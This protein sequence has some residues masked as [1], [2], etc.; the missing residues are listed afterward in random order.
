MT[1]FQRLISEAEQSS[2]LEADR[3]MDLRI[4]VRTYGKPAHL[5]RIA[6]QLHRHLKVTFGDAV[7]FMTLGND[8]LID[9]FED[10]A[11]EYW[12]SLP[13]SKLPPPV[14]HKRGRY[15]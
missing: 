6:L 2:D 5:W 10:D 8:E 13:P 9:T 3:S 7:I 11:G 15:G 12:H 1:S 14:P 4:E